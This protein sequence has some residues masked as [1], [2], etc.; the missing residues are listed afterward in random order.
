MN[1][2]ELVKIEKELFNLIEQEI[3]KKEYLVEEFVHKYP[4]EVGKI[5]YKQ[6]QNNS[7]VKNILM[8]SVVIKQVLPHIADEFYIPTLTKLIKQEDLELRI[9]YQTIQ[10]LGWRGNE[11]KEAIPFLLRNLEENV[12]LKQIS[13]IALAKIGYE[14]FDELV[15]Y[16]LSTLKNAKVYNTRMNAAR[17]LVSHESNWQEKLPGLIDA[18]EKD[19]DFRVRQK[20][21]RYFG[22]INEEGVKEA[23]LK[24]YNED[25]HPI[26]RT[27]AK[28]SLVDLGD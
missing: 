13:A 15:P 19:P 24:A 21:A 7:F 1:N 4:Y 9:R 5:I 25:S 23:L 20:I 22:E 10:L 28:T 18:L 14:K 6:V 26:V 27:V 3:V 12:S 11:A 2:I 17:L 16:L 8:F